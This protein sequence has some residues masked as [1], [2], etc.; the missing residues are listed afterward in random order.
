MGQGGI[1]NW[2]QYPHWARGPARID[3]DE[4]VLNE[5]RAR[6]YFLYESTDLLFDLAEIAADPSNLDPRRV[7]AFVRRYGLFWHGADELGTGKCREPLR[8]WWTES[9]ELAVM[10]DFYVRLKEATTAGSAG[11][12][13]AMPYDFM[14]FVE[15]GD[16]EDD[17]SYIEVA[18]LFLAEVI[19]RKLEGCGVGIA[20]SLGLDVERKGPLDFLLTQKPPDLVTAAYAQ[21]AM[22]MVRRAPIEECQ[23]C[24]RMFIPES[25][26]QKYH[27]KSCASTS[28]WRRWKERQDAQ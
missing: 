27:S 6:P 20:S 12:L 28:R 22:A 13:R 7:V 9:Y 25:G 3:G 19:S 23:G 8:K 16:R 14:K 26:K 2:S 1:R 18:S 15:G 10:A 21:L 4:I 24:G 17:E 11:S 5:D